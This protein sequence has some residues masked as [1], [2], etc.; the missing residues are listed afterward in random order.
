MKT[1]AFITNRRFLCC[2]V[3][4]F[5]LFFWSCQKEKE[6]P[7][8][9]SHASSGGQTEPESGDV[10]YNAVMDVDGHTYD[11]VLIGNKIWMIQNLKTTRYSNGEEIPV[12]VPDE[13]RTSTEPL[14]FVPNGN[15]S[16]VEQY[17]YLYNWYAVMH[18]ASSSSSNP[19]RVQGVCPQG[20]HV[21]SRAEWEQLTTFIGMQSEY[22]C[23][24]EK[25]NVAKAMA[26]TTGW[27]EAS[28]TCAVGN[29]QYN[30]NATHFSAFPAGLGD[31]SVNNNFTKDAYF[32]SCTQS[33]IPGWD[34]YA[35]DFELDYY[36]ATTYIYAPCKGNAMAV[37][38]VRD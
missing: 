36:S 35:Y 5:P 4:F 12:G 17:G 29:N 20:W 11:A 1:K 23:N 25:Y 6:Q 31:I 24:G 15:G 28:K 27:K 18:G 22:Q 38:C 7:S 33:A 9:P 3:M 19:S 10:M 8:A 26:S 37:R 30:N 2:V 13:D 16:Y 34:M 32:W 14:R 21:P